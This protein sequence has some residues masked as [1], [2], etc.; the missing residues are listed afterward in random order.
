MANSESVRSA[1]GF[2]SHWTNRCHCGTFV[3]CD[4]AVAPSGAFQALM[5]RRGRRGDESNPYGF[6]EDGSLSLGDEVTRGTAHIS[7][8]FTGVLARHWRRCVC[9]R[10]RAT[11]SFM[12]QCFRVHTMPWFPLSFVCVHAPTCLLR[13]QATSVFR[14]PARWT[15]LTVFQGQESHSSLGS[16][17][18]ITFS[19]CPSLRLPQPLGEWYPLVAA[20]ADR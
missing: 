18:T 3:A 10:V 13:L 19:A 8:W 2:L 1:K 11:N 17:S 6:H 5:F 4:G 15:I 20:R 7:S 9:G 12:C 16:K 14:G